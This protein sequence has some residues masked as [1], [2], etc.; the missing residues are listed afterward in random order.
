MGKI[1]DF[2]IPRSRTINAIT[3]LLYEYF[4]TVID[5]PDTSDDSFLAAIVSA[6]EE[7]EDAEYVYG[8]LQDEGIDCEMDENLEEFWNSLCAFFD[9]G[10][11]EGEC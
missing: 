3:D 7:D 1:L 8:I 11:M 10:S 5:I 2:R 9:T 4:D 6:Y